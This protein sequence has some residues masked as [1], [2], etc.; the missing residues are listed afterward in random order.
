MNYLYDRHPLQYIEQYGFE[1][2]WYEKSWC[3]YGI[4][5][6]GIKENES[7]TARITNNYHT[8]ILEFIV[9]D[10]YD[11]EELSWSKTVEIP[12]EYASQSKCD[13]YQF[14]DWIDKEIEKFVKSNSNRE[15]MRDDKR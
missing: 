9:Y 10:K 6:S 1:W 2:D 11:D 7:V 5:G 13:C 15:V 14:I 8:I 12:K 4:E 3:L